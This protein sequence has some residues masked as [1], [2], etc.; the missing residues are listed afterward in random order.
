MALL[1]V[2][3]GIDGV[4]VCGCQPGECHYK[5]GTLVSACK[6]GLLGRMLDHM[7]IGNGRVRF[8][9]IGTQDRGRIRGEVDSMLE[10]LAAQREVA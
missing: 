10:N 8:A 2:R 4:L 3:S 7:Q 1:A 9:Q 5:R 6:I